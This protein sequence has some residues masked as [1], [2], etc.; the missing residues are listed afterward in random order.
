M[1]VDQPVLLDEDEEQP[2]EGELIARYKL[3]VEYVGPRYHGSQR[4]GNKGKTVQE[5][6]EVAL[7]K[8]THAPPPSTVFSGRTDAGV[9]A[10]G[11]VVHA[12][13]CRRSRRGQPLPPMEV[14]LL[15][16]AL[17]D[18]LPDSCGVVAARRVPDSFDARRSAVCRTYLYRIACAAAATP[19][20]PDADGETRRVDVC[21]ALMR[22]GWFSSLDKQR[23]LC[24][25]EPL[26]LARMRAAA[27][28]LEGR[29]D[30]SAFRHVRCSAASAVRELPWNG[31]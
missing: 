30:F 12:D 6:L 23:A 18:L 21:P 29:H 26:D 4:Q 9:H 11:Q 28:A 27:R 25:N 16:N 31:A 3:T 19:P 10:V 20:P 5:E 1:E 14:P 7:G 24:L 13:L 8:L 15:L 22:R 2:A 17:N